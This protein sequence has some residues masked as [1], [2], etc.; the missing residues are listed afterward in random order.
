MGGAGPGP[1]LM[2]GAFPGPGSRPAC[3]LNLSLPFLCPRAV[4]QAHHVDDE[5]AEEST[6]PARRE[7]GL[8]EDTG[9]HPADEGVSSVLPQALGRGVGWGGATAHSR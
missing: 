8:G 9:Q 3:T 2:D 4:F 5:P 6:R 7:G 1:S